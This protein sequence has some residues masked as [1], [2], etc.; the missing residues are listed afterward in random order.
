MYES[1]DTETSKKEKHSDF[2]R[3]AQ[4]AFEKSTDFMDANLR[5]DWESNIR[6]FNSEHPKGSK[7]SSENY[8]NRSKVFRP[9]T[10]ASVRKNE[11]A[12]AAAFFSTKDMVNIRPEDDRNPIQVASAKI[13]NKLVN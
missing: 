4:S 1:D 5:K 12:C 9:K 8:K 11:A 7:Y 6:A 10:R 3:L 13:M 2:L